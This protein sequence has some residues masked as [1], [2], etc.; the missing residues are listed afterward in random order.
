MDT[1]RVQDKSA[2]RPL[3][4]RE[5]E[6]MG[7]VA[8]HYRSKAI[9]RLLGTSP[10]T[11]DTQIASACRKLGA[12]DRDEAVRRLLALEALQR[13]GE[14]PLEGWPPISAAAPISS[15][16]ALTKGALHDCTIIQ[17]PVPGRPSADNDLPRTLRESR[18]GRT[19][20]EPDHGALSGVGAARASAV[21]DGADGS[22]RNPAFGQLPRG[23]TAQGFINRLTVPSG[24][25]LRLLGALILA[26]GL[27][28]LLP[29]AL[30]GA[31]ALQKT[32]ESLS[33]P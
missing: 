23:R 22:L 6:V 32:I 20:A 2:G 16:E 13:I 10:K 17:S 30:A 24:G 4:D 12:S 26:L 21:S 28:V 9:S 7:Y 18:A 3:T 14:K 31:V 25:G 8:A 27:A 19:E 11:I 15:D 33:T 5:R 1:G 29:A